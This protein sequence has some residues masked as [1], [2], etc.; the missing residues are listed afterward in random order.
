MHAFL[1]SVKTS[2][3]NFRTEVLRKNCEFKQ[4]E[5]DYKEI[6]RRTEPIIQRVNMPDRDPSGKREL[7]LRNREREGSRRLSVRKVTRVDNR[8]VKEKAAP[9]EVRPFQAEE[10]TAFRARNR[11][12]T[13]ITKAQGNTIRFVEVRPLQLN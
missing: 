3:E 13:P 4:I 11:V 5:T 8:L 9:V 7:R 2:G 10:F 6:K 12:F 1:Y